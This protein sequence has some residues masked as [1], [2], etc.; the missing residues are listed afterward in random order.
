MNKGLSPLVETRDF[1]S[2]RW[3]SL[4]V[5]S[6]GAAIMLIGLLGASEKDPNPREFTQNPHRDTSACV[7]CHTSVKGGRESLRFDGDVSRLCQSCHDG[8]RAGREAHPVGMVPSPALAP[9]IPPEFPLANGVLTC[10]S[11]HEVSAGCRPGDPNAAPNYRLLRRWQASDPLLFCSGCHARERYSA[12]NA[13]DQ[14][15]AGRVKTETCTWCHVEVP[16]V[17]SYPPEDAP[18]TLRGKSFAVCANCHAVVE[19]HPT[20]THLGAAPSPQL[21]W[22]ICAYELQPKLRLPFERLFEYAKAA[23]RAPRSIPLDENDRITCYT[24][25]NPHEKGLLPDGNPRALG[26]E[27][28][29][30]ERHRL[31]ARDGKLCVVCH[32][33]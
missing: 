4:W 2:L 15:E 33:K 30:A 32:E 8:R 6:P 21:L 7:S 25:H 1:A 11:C 20:G 27:P 29:Q 16:D 9:R 28:E 10:L 5:I 31:R 23:Q 17:N 18:Y 22:H 12:F 14:L 13:H 3:G 24:C 19:G 26:A